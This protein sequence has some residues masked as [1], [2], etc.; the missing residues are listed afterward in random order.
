MPSLPERFVASLTRA[1]SPSER[2]VLEATAALTARAD[3]LDLDAEALRSEVAARCAQAISSAAFRQRLKRLNSSLKARGAPFLLSS[4]GGRIRV[5]KTAEWD[6]EQRSVEVEKQLSRHSDEGTAIAAGA[7]IPP[8]AR[9]EKMPDLL[10]MFS[11][12]W[13]SQGSVGSQQHR[14]QIEFFQELER[15]LKHP[16]EGIPAIGLWRDTEQLRTSDQGDPQ[17]DGACRKAFLC[18]LMLSDKYPHSPACLHEAEYFLDADGKN[19]AGKQCVVVPV[20]VRR[21][22]APN[23]FRA[24]TRIWV[25]DDRSPDLLAVW[26]KGGVE[27]RVAFVRKVAAEIFRAAQE[28]VAQPDQ[29]ALEDLVERF[30]GRRYF[31]HR[32]DDIVGPRAA[33]SAWSRHCRCTRDLFAL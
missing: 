29:L 32:P 9:P 11:Y 24:G 13:L 6:A 8:L 25:V 10:A 5:Q 14:I 3:S 23:R 2:V 33:G 22:D 21:A 4:A 7:S 12:A 31:E 1:L 15:Q 28:H 30:A 16:P 17:I 19:Q 26:R 18:V 27:G 20:N